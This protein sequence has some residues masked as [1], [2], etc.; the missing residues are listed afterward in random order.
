MQANNLKTLWGH[1]FQVVSEGLSETDVVA[2]VE[3]L[4]SQ[5]K[6]NLEKP[7]YVA[8][9]QKLAMRTV[10]EAERLAD[11]TK[12][13]AEEESKRRSAEIASAADK[14]AGELTEQATRTAA[15]IK[16]EA[17]KRAQEKI[18]DL[19][20]TFITMKKEALKEFQPLKEL[21]GRMQFFLSS[22]EAFLSMLEIEVDG[23][24]PEVV[25]N[26]E[27]SAAEDWAKQLDGEKG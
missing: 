1:E 14:A 12:E 4:M 24:K 17:R 16:A 13:Q 10:A 27:V 2:F 21:E 3:G 20:A 8:A 19:Q 5:H 18:A 23:Q 11:E 25:E 22:F 15:A 26:P 6:A 9:L 7:N